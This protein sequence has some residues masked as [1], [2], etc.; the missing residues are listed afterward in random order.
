MDRPTLGRL[1][2]RGLRCCILSPLVVFT[3]VRFGTELPVA[4]GDIAR[5][6]IYPVQAKIAGGA[7]GMAGQQGQDEVINQLLVFAHVR[8]HNPNQTPITLPGRLGYRHAR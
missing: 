5:L 6:A 2:L 7:A 1:A 4:T 8:L 3:W